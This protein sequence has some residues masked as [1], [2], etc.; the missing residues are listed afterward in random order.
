ML[1]HAQHKR[2]TTKRLNS[3]LKRVLRLIKRK[4]SIIQYSGKLVLVIP[5]QL[6]SFIVLENNMILPI[7]IGFKNMYSAKIDD[8]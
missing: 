7:K 1:F 8:G 2:K 3:K 4:S 6:K 5:A